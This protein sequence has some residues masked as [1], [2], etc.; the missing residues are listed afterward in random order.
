MK[1]STKMTRVRRAGLY[2]MVDIRIKERPA[3][4]YKTPKIQS[5]FL[6]PRR[7]ISAPP[8]KVPTMVAIKPKT[9]VTVPISV[10]E[11]PY[12]MT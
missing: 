2:P 1:F 11:N 10:F 12:P 9:L 8:A 7:V 3:V 6:V 4:A 5:D